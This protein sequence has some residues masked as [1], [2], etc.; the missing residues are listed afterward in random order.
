[1]SIHD[2]GHNNG[3]QGRKMRHACYVTIESCSS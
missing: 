3:E 1:V 2:N